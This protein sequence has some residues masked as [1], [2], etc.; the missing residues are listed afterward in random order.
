MGNVRVDDEVWEKLMRLKLKLRD[1]SL[2]IV[3]KKMLK[4][5]SKLNLYQELK[6]I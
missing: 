5:I 1:K 4:M 3:I 2:N 6:D